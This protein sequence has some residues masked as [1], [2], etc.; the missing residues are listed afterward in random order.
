MLKMRYFTISF[1]GKSSESSKGIRSKLRMFLWVRGFS[2]NFLHIP[3]SLGS[4]LR[5]NI[6]IIFLKKWIQ[7]T[8]SL[9]NGFVFSTNK[10]KWLGRDFIFVQQFSLVSP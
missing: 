7:K 2:G 9:Y 8:K 10:M 6:Q 5:V 3:E 4:L 1:Y